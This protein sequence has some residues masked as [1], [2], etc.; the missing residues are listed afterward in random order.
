MSQI[1]WVMHSAF[2][3]ER[4]DDDVIDDNDDDDDDVSVIDGV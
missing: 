3:E 4:D 2:V 1:V